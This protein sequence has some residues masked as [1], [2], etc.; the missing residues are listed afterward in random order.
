M[1]TIPDGW[2]AVHHTAGNIAQGSTIETQHDVLVLLPGEITE[3]MEPS[4]KPPPSAASAPMVD[5]LDDDHGWILDSLQLEDLDIAKPTEVQWQ[6]HGESESA[7][8]VARLVKLSTSPNPVGGYPAYDINGPAP[9]IYQ[10]KLEEELFNGPF[11]MWYECEGTPVCRPVC[12]PEVLWML[13]VDNDCMC[14]WLLLPLEL[15]VQ[16]A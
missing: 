5:T 7:P 3:R 1:T 11:G 6:A 2:M 10:L 14:T 12:L 4:L 8:R 15:V 9:S 13:G 16:C